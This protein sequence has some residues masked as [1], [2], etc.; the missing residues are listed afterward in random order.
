MRTSIYSLDLPDSRRGI[1]CVRVTARDESIARTATALAQLRSDFGTPAVE[2]AVKKA[3]NL[4]VRFC[5][6]CRRATLHGDGTCLECGC[7]ALSER[8]KNTSSMEPLEFSR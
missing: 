4:A 8:P 3:E 7:W 1:A 5:G 6:E 2:A